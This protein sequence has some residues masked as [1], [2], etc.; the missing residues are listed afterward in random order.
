VIGIL[1]W[2]F[3]RGI[4]PAQSVSSQNA[5][6]TAIAVVAGKAMSR[7]SLLFCRPHRRP[8]NIGAMLIDRRR[9]HARKERLAA[10]SNYSSRTG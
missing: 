7:W 9:G 8:G 6:I 1:L 4:D 2:N 10:R 3:D 5:P